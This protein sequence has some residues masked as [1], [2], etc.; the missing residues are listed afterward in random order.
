M[1]TVLV[2]SIATSAIAY[3]SAFRRFVVNDLALWVWLNERFRAN[4]GRMA[5]ILA[6][7]NATRLLI[8]PPLEL[9]ALDRTKSCLRDYVMMVSSLAAAVA[10]APHLPSNRPHLADIPKAERTVSITE[11]DD[12]ESKDSRYYFEN[13]EAQD[14]W[15]KLSDVDPI[16]FQHMAGPK[17]QASSWS[18]TSGT[19]ISLSSGEKLQDPDTAMKFAQI[20]KHFNWVQVIQETPTG[21]AFSARPGLSHEE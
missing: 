2:V 14:T 5:L 12:V 6:V 16:V 9:S 8:D 13:S 18:N 4:F 11:A 1:L 17:S 7:L 19:S 10:T 3:H 20:L 15:E 21:D